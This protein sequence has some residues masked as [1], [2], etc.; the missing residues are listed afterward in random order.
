MKKTCIAAAF[1]AAFFLSS[2]SAIEETVPV[3]GDAEAVDAM[4][5]AADES[6]TAPAA[7]APKKTESA[8][9]E[10]TAGETEAPIDETET[11]SDDVI[12]SEDG[13]EAV[14]DTVITSESDGSVSEITLTFY[15]TTLT[16]GDTVM[17]IVTMHPEDAPDKSEIWTS[18][19]ESVA[20]VDDMGNIT[21]QG[22]G[23]CVVKVQSAVCPEISAEVAVRVKKAVTEPTYI[24]GIII[25]NK[26]YALPKDYEPGVDPD[27]QAAFDKMRS[28]AAGEGLDLYISSAFRS[29]DY[30]AGLYNR[31]VERS[32]KAEADR[33][34]AR[35][36]HSE[37]QTGLAFDLNTIDSSF[38]DTDEYVWL[39]AHCAE[40]GF[41][42]RYPENGE[43]ITGYMYEPW[44]IRYLGRETAQ[45][46]YD[47]GLTLEEYLGIDSV[48]DE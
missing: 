17:P 3:Q 8:S 42:I 9:F 28:A 29:Y 23:E 24:D 21:A 35:P 39:K 40:Y 26:T 22:A 2:C 7:E 31:Y 14:S 33:Y 44:H 5:T 41:I 20:V 16:A 11:V 47:S 25:A 19:D 30:Q 15:E 45:K 34:S 32:G 38:A 10:E 27:A 48:Y 36:G 46:V 43:E 6:E 37:H 12:T 13:T 18:S 1:A 4:V